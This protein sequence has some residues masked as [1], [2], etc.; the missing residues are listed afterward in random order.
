M[1]SD[2]QQNKALYSSDLIGKKWT[3]PQLLPGIDTTI[4]KNG[5]YPFVM[6]DGTTLYF[7]AQGPKSIGGYDIFVT[8]Y[9]A[10]EQRF[11]TPE[12]IGMPFNSEGNDYLYAIDDIEKLGVFVTDRNQPKGLVCI[13]F[14]IPNDSHQ[15]YDVT[16]IG[17]N[18]LKEYARISSIKDTWK[19]KAK[20]NDALSRLKRLADKGSKTKGQQDFAFEVNNRTIYTQVTQ[21]KQSSRSFVRDYMKY[22]QKYQSL[23]AT[24][25][26][27]R[28]LYENANLS[29][30]KQM[31]S[32]LR[33]TEKEFEIVEVKL[34]QLEKTI[35]NIEN[36]EL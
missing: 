12:N 21:F 7:A 19:S 9:D 26:D 13:Y 35:R 33:E 1:Q 8:R 4:Y 36:S 31:E 28:V 17:D 25:T 18:K 23:T 29:K 22:R 11:L 15:I 20:R 14:F 10:G 6:T 2:N 5:N 3:Y 30:R 27:L 32:I 24:L 16:K 34:E